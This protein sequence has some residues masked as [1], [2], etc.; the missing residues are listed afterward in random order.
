MSDCACCQLVAL[1]KIASE[2]MNIWPQILVMLYASC[3]ALDESFLSLVCFIKA[4]LIVQNSYMTSETQS[5]FMGSEHMKA[6]HHSKISLEKNDL[7]KILVL[8]FCKTKD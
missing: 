3:V 4:L 7:L 1:N 8:I 6:E 2:A 5:N